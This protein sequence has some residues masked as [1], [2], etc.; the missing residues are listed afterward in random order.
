MDAV[1]HIVHFVFI[2]RVTSASGFRT[3][4]SYGFRMSF[5][6]PP[7]SFRPKTCYDPS[8]SGFLKGAD[9]SDESVSL[10]NPLQSG[11][12]LNML[13]SFVITAVLA[14]V[15][16]ASHRITLRVSLPRGKVNSD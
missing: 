14:A 13:T 3:S 8:L 15:A 16:N 12:Y 4:V 2:S 6:Y 7:G 1:K 9:D 10:G 11:L 5:S